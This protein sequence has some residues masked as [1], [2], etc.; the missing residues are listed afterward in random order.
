MSLIPPK[1]S[2]HF[3]EKERNHLPSDKP[4]ILIVNRM[5]D[6]L[7]DVAIA[8]LLTEA[9]IPFSIL[10]PASGVRTGLPSKVYVQDRSFSLQEG[11][12]PTEGAFAKLIKTHA[13]SA[14]CLV[15]CLE[16][17]LRRQGHFIRHRFQRLLI[18]SLCKTGLPMVPAHMQRDRTQEVD[19]P[20]ITMRIGKAISPEAQRT[21]DKPTVLR[22][23][24]L[25]RIF[26]LGS[27][28]DVRKFYLSP[29]IAQDALTPIATPVEVELLKADVAALPQNQLI[30]SH[31]PFEIHLAS[32]RQIPNVLE[33]I[34]R[35]RELTFREV[36][37][38]TGMAKDLDEYDLYYSQLFIWDK[39]NNKIVGGYR[40]GRGDQIFAR[41]GAEGFYVHS[42]F[43]IKKGF[44]PIMQ[45]AV[46][47]GR[48][49]VVPD[50]QRKLLPLFLLWKG[51]LHFLIQNPQYR[52]LYGPVSISKHYSFLS[53]SMIVSFIKKHYF[54]DHLARFLQPRTPFKVKVDKEV[55]VDVLLENFDGEISALDQF[56]ED[57]EPDHFRLPVL[58]KKYIKQNARFISFNLDPNFSDA[59]DGFIILDVKDVPAE[60]IERLQ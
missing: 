60:T 46:E 37:E 29:T 59:L 21:F 49:Y 53:K 1:L 55:S 35:L 31:G 58:I 51:I 6:G 34:G 13:P 47:L 17:G 14:G 57:I 4:F 3:Q 27:P 33:E 36:G 16:H 11:V 43:K 48:S 7:E 20:H 2:L 8:Q 25:S 32:A 41:Y 42:L 28:L 12:M 38:G 39:E 30:A 9:G 26:A 23:F 50:Y 15:V 52:Y 56:I 10:A 45:Q 18:K 24:L 40:L 44:Y 19:M 54:N 22:K 5:E